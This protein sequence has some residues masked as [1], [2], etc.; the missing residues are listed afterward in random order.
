MLAFAPI[1]VPPPI[2]AA[3]H[4]PGHLKLAKQA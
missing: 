4:N 2:F 1:S 3:S